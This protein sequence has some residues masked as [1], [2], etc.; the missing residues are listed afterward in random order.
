MPE[1]SV[2][3]WPP[4]CTSSF[5]SSNP[6]AYPELLEWLGSLG[7][8]EV[9]T[10]LAIRAAQERRRELD[11]A[12][13]D[14]LP[15][16]SEGFFASKTRTTILILAAI[17]LLLIVIVVGIT[18][19]PAHASAYAQGTVASSMTEGGNGMLQEAGKVE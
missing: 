1:S 14:S 17:A 16:P 18:Q 4:A 3:C 2:L 12:Q 10:A 15:E 19:L 8:S 6:A 5:L 13:H 9:N 11:T 7:D